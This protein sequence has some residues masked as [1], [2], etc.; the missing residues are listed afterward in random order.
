M[1]VCSFHLASIW[2]FEAER[3]PR[4]GNL[5]RARAPS[6]AQLDTAVDDRGDRSVWLPYLLH[7]GVALVRHG[8]SVDGIGLSIG[9]EGDHAGDGAGQPSAG[10]GERP[11]ISLVTGGQYFAFAVPRGG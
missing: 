1:R 11:L 10:N 4:T 5:A 2:C 8:Q 3:R 7:V 9:R 6:F